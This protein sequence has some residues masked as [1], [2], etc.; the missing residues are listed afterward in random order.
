MRDLALFVPFPLIT[1]REGRQAWAGKQLADIGCTFE[2]CFNNRLQ[3]RR[4]RREAGRG[5]GGTGRQTA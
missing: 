1:E 5:R 3:L 2:R 4:F